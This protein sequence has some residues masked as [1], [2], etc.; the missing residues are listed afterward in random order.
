M[1]RI[2]QTFVIVR[3]EGFLEVKLLQGEVTPK[4]WWQI[5]SVEFN[6][7]LALRSTRYKKINVMLVQGRQCNLAWLN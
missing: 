3:S 7:F 6:K 4:L 5:L 2:F 1:V